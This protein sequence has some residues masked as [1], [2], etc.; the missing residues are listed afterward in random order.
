MKPNDYE[1]SEI[2]S[3]SYQLPKNF[4]PDKLSEPVSIKTPFGEYVS[5]VTFKDGILSYYRK[6]IQHSGYHA[7]KEYAAFKEFCKTVN[8]ND[9]QQIAFKIISN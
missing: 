3:L 1:K 7:A 6:L 4:V 8:K 5:S 9:N 2:D